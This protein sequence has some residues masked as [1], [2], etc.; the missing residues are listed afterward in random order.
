[1]AGINFSQILKVAIKDNVFEKTRATANRWFFTKTQSFRRNIRIPDQGLDT[2][3]DAKA[4]PRIRY[5]MVGN[6]YYFSYEPKAAKTLPYYDRFPLV[7]PLEMY[8]DGILGINFHYLPPIQRGILMDR[9]LEHFE[10]ENDDKRV[11][12]RF[13]FSYETLESLDSRYKY[14]RPALK[15][16]NFN[17]MRSRMLMLDEEEWK[18][19]LFLPV[20]RF[21]GA[22]PTQVWSESRKQFI[23]G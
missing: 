12:N 15:R 7:M 1:M 9:I 10:N 22:R 4:P 16:Y 13:R 11:L 20:H 23:K 17:R 18:V 5:T 6:L 3:N 2:N 19:A 14:Y 21:V 8:T